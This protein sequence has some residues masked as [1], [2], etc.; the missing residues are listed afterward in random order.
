MNLR[1]IV[2]KYW[3]FG[4]GA[5][6][7][8]AF[9]DKNEVQ[10][11]HEALKKACDKSGPDYYPKFKERCDEYI[12]LPHRK[13]ARGQGGVFFDY[14]S[15]DINSNFKLVKDLGEAFYDIYPKLIRDKFGLS[16]TQNDKK[17]QLARRSLYAEFN[18]L[19]DRGVRFGLMTDGKIDAIFMSMPPSAEWL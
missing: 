3:W 17:I 10:K 14:L 4:G 13:E 8:P 12:Y 1:F 19:Y 9:V 18:L 16:W 15:D 7:T 6:M 11:F 2:T 5:D